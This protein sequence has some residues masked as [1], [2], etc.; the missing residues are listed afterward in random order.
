MKTV[1]IKELL[2]NSATKVGSTQFIAIDGHGGSGKSTLAD[3]L[4]KALNAQVI[5]TDDFAGWGDGGEWW[6]SVVDK[7]FKP[8]QKGSKVL[9]YER[10]KWWENHHPEPAVDE[11]VTP[12][13]ILEGVSSLRNEFRDYIALGIFVDTPYDICL[14]RGVERDSTVG[15]S[16]EEISKLWHEWLDGELSYFRNMDPKAYADIIIDGTKPFAEQITELQ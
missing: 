7:V 16:K 10:T 14:K 12:I 5:H 1:S 2:L 8:I 4:S 15:K 11:P 9:N 3:M 6:P 13:M